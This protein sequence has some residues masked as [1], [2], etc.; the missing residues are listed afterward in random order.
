MAALVAFDLTASRSPG[1]RDHDFHV[2]DRPK[3]RATKTSQDADAMAEALRRSL[4]T[5][6]PEPQPP[7]PQPPQPQPPQ[8]QPH[9]ASDAEFAAELHKAQLRA[10]RD[11][12]NPTKIYDPAAEGRR[13][14]LLRNLGAGGSCHNSNASQ[15]SPSA[16]TERQQGSLRQ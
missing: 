5:V 1:D 16:S 10:S 11:K 3:S 9:V 8:P 7:Q 2:G 14:Q 12:R 4:E 15:L 6:W 13:P